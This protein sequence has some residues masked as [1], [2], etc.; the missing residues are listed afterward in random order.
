MNKVYKLINLDTGEET[1]FPC[2][3]AISR[4]L[5]K[6]RSWCH[7]IIKYKEGIYKNFKIEELEANGEMFANYEKDNVEI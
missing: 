5:G 3:Y 1:L 6:S 7:Y 4:H 2:Q